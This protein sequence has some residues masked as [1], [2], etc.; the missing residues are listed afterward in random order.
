VSGAI[1]AVVLVLWG[2]AA[3]SRASADRLWGADYFPNLP[4]ITHTG[5]T[6][7]FYD[8]LLKGKSVVV[9]VIYTRCR[10]RCPLETAKLAQVQRLLGD[11]VGR[12][13]F[14]Y[15]ISI[16][17]QFDTAEVLSEYAAKFHAGPGW[18][19]LTGS[20]ADID[21]ISKK[22]GLYSPPNP[23]DP[24][25]HIPS[26]LVGNEV[27][28]QWMR[29]SSVD[30]P[31]FL[32]RTIGDWLNSWKTA[33]R[34][35][36]TYANA[37]PLK[38]SP[39][40]YTFKQH[41]TACHT[42]GQGP[43]IGPDLLGVTRT[44]NRE[45]L[46]RFIYAPDKMLAD[47]DPI[48]KELFEQYKNVRMPNLAL[49]REDVVA[50]VNYLI[51]QDAESASPAPSAVKSSAPVPLMPLVDPYLRIH[52]ALSADR[53][54]GV[55]EAAQQIVSEATKIGAD[56]APMRSAAGLLAQAVDLQAA[57]DAFGTLSDAVITFAKTSNSAIGDGVSIAYCPM[58]RKYWLQKGTSIRN[59]YYGKAM[60]ECGRIESSLPG[61]TK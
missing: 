6:V 29:N 7:R 38:F 49:S 13:I 57:R 15:S 18:L 12:D 52:E 1:A 30:N 36:N 54:S 19:F 21:L 4:L 16:D 35:S 31:K 61:V 28:G 43:H 55:A 22:T 32:A 33:K 10:D 8:D 5:K 58:L 27:T 17:P 59:P 2:I 37:A 39:G 41:C 26:L 45:W 11:R 40:E 3:A 47:G 53:I 42:L 51:K 9:N 14:F 44:R 60:L 23:S 50:V 46:A 34:D 56:A 20:Q 24:D 25:G 48:A